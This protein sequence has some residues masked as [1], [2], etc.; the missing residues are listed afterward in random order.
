[1]EIERGVGI[2]SLIRSGL[3]SKFKFKT[4]SHDV[5]QKADT[6]RRTSS[7]VPF[8]FTEPDGK[9]VTVSAKCI[10]FFNVSPNEEPLFEIEILIDEV[11]K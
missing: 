6:S 2:V 4:S 11:M 1:M 3:A 7:Y 8:T 5:I 10:R 9:S